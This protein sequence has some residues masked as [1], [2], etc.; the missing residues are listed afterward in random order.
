VC[1]IINPHIAHTNIDN[2]LENNKPWLLYNDFTI[3][4][5]AY[6]DVTLFPSWRHP[7]IVMFAQNNYLNDEILHTTPSSVDTKSTETS[8]TQQIYKLDTTTIPKSVFKLPT[9]V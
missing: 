6:T 9:L 1:H 8:K 4:N 2:K 3:N 5:V 7:C